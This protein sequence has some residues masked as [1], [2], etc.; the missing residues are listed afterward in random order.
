MAYDAK[1]PAPGVRVCP[2][3]KAKVWLSLSQAKAARKIPT[4]NKGNYVGRGVIRLKPLGGPLGL[5]VHS[6]V[7]SC[8]KMLCSTSGPNSKRRPRSPK[9]GPMNLCF[10]GQMHTDRQQDKIVGLAE[11]KSLRKMSARLSGYGRPLLNWKG[12][13]ES[14]SA[15]R[16]QFTNQHPNFAGELARIEQEHAKH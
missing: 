3:P 10:S 8:P 11:L 14:Y 9:R 13:A 16:L 2:S 5:D 7:R 1:S 15:R 6:T 12:F 4:D